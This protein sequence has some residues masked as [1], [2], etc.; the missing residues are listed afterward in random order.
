MASVEYPTRL[1]SPPVMP[2][3]KYMPSR[4]LTGIT[5]AMTAEVMTL[6]DIGRSR[7]STAIRVAELASVGRKLELSVLVLTLKGSKWTTS[8]VDALGG[9]TVC[10]NN[11]AGEQAIKSGGR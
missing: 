7:R 5:S 6:T 3:A 4:M 11:H 8:S 10:A 1:T 2:A 9:G